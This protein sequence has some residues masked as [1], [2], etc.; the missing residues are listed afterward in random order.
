MKQSDIIPFYGGKYPELFE[1]ERRCMDREGKVIDFLN[2]S[3]PNGKILDIGAG[4]G[5]TAEKVMHSSRQIIAMEP[6]DNMIDQHK[7]LV[8]AK[9]T[10]QHIPFHS[11]TFEAAYATWAFFFNG[12]PD[13]DQGLK[14]AKRVVKSGGDIIIVDNYGHDEFLSYSKQNLSSDSKMWTERG[15]TAHFIETA[16]IF[17]SVEEARTLLSFY[18]GEAG[19]TVEKTTFEYKVVAYTKQVE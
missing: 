16:F 17:D 5:F 3:L 2:S 7:D 15:F 13:L 18:F 9:G 8:W 6:D 12:I 19:Q 1:I 4:N 11:N 14:E 10:A